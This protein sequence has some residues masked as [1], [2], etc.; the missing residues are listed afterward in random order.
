M[1]KGFSPIFPVSTPSC[2]ELEL[3]VDEVQVYEGRI[4][5]EVGIDL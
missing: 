4:D 5:D 3:S 1:E 2:L